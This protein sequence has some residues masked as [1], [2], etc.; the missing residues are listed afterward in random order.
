MTEI[1]EELTMG[2][3]L[4]TTIPLFLAHFHLDMLPDGPDLLYYINPLS[5]CL[6]LYSSLHCTKNSVT[7]ALEHYADQQ[8]HSSHLC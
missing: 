8:H 1:L 5:K 7:R 4:L 2:L 3:C 6:L